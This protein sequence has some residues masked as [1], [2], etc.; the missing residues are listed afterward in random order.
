MEK[1]LLITGGAGFIGSNFCRYYLNRYPHST[2]VVIDALT[3]AG[4]KNS[5]AGLE[6]YDEFQFIHGDIKDVT[7]VKQ[8]MMD[9]HI[10][11]IVHF[12]AESHV[13]RSIIDP[14]AFIQ[15]NIIGT[16]SLLQAAKSLWVDNQQGLPHHRFHHISTDEV[17]GSLESEELPFNETTPY[18][19]NSPY[20]ASKAGS[21]HLVRAYSRTYGLD[22]TISNCSNNYGPYHFPEKLI[23][24]TIVNILHN[25]PI[26]IY[27]DGLQIRDWLYVDDHCRGITDILNNG[28]SGESYNIGG[29]NEW[30]NI[31]IVTLICKI[32]DDAFISRPEFLKI[33][34]HS[35]P[36]LG[37]TSFELVRYVSDRLGHDRRYAINAA[38]I[39]NELGFKPSIDF[40]AGIRKTIFWYLENPEWW[41]S[42]MDGSY[43]QLTNNI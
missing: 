35:A 12:A 20:A 38:K 39:T 32:V 8:I 33:Y 4:N 13:D 11:T 17:Y 21:D 22:I 42:I 26:P 7:C 27:G 30:A 14:D 24:L 41:R 3:Y 10:N 25:K 37:R 15:T 16:H 28:N 36:A 23:P 43:T 5:L 2:L 19:P 29:C 40:P 6:K 18:A 9:N 1:R 34:P 31:D